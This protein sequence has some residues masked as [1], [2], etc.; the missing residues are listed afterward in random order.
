[1]STYQPTLNHLIGK[2]TALAINDPEI[3]CLS[4]RLRQRSDEDLF[5]YLRN[6]LADNAERLQG[7]LMF[8]F[9]A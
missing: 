4:A 1:M 6:I 9:F 7:G 5:L 2:T 3:K 8:N